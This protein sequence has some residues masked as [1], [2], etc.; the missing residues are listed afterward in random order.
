MPKEEKVVSGRYMAWVESYG[1]YDVGELFEQQNGSMGYI[2]TCLETKAG[3]PFI[4]L[5]G[6][7]EE[8]ISV[9]PDASHSLKL[10]YNAATA[11]MEK[12]N[13]AVLVV[14]S[15]D[16]DQSLLNFPI[17]LDLNGSPVIEA[18]AARLYAKE[19]ETTNVTIPVSD[20]DNDDFTV[21]LTDPEGIAAITEVVADASD[22][23]AEITTDENGIVTVKG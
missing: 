11:R 15:N 5:D 3:S 18:P 20:P 4:S 19:G 22:A 2:L 8:T 17:Y 7:T 21:E 12:G 16:P 13:K 6:A 23:G 14:K 10:Q 9:E 1:W